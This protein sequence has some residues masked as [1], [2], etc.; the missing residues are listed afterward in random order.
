MDLKRFLISLCCFI[1]LSLS[2]MVYGENI[3]IKNQWNDEFGDR[4]LSSSPTLIKEGSTLLI[5]S[6]KF[7]ENLSVTIMGEDGRQVYLEL[8]NVVVDMEYSILVDTLPVGNYYITVM[9]GNNYIIGYFHV[10]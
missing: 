5:L 4:S 3:E 8:H 2:T 10:G 7:L 9:Q 1:L 6:D